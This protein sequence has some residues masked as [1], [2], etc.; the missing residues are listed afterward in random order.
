MNI[1]W[2]LSGLI[3][4][5]GELRRLLEGGGEYPPAYVRI[6]ND[7]LYYGY[8]D[9]QGQPA[10]PGVRH[11]S[12]L[13][14]GFVK[15]ADAP[16]TAIAAYAR[17][18]GVLEICPAHRRPGAAWH[19]TK[20]GQPACRP[21]GWGTEL[22]EPIARWRDCSRYLRTLLNV[23]AAVHMGTLGRPE[24]WDLLCTTDLVPAGKPP[25]WDKFDL[26]GA[27]FR[28]SWIILK[29]V[30]L[31]HLMPYLDW[32]DPQHA[33]VRLSGWGGL[34]GALALELLFITAR[35][36]GLAICSACGTPYVPSRRPRKGE[37]PYCPDCGRRAAVRDAAKRYRLKAKQ[38]AHVRR[39]NV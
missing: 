17:R 13:L 39:P 34:T 35:T 32:T 27:C 2:S 10:P 15:L 5:R 1:D 24:D 19:H 21:M 16:A 9:H 29:W 30:E 28:L 20:D 12:G 36:D 14:E 11:G 7:M 22:Y 23:V 25:V 31:V 18:W 37:H 4:D 8:R 3:R 38:R 33:A 6:E 26:K